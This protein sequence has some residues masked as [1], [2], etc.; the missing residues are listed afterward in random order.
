MLTIIA[1]VIIFGLLLTGAG[2]LFIRAFGATEQNRTEQNRTEQNRTRNPFLYWIIGFVAT[3]IIATAATL[4]APLNGMALIIFTAVGLCG[5][6]LVYRDYRSRLARCDR[7]GK[8][9]FAG[10]AALLVIY[11]ASKSAFYYVYW[12]GYDTALYHAQIVRWY[13]EYGAVCGV[14]NLHSRLAFNSSYL[15][16]AA[17]LDNWIF[18][19]RSAWLMPALIFSG[20][21]LYFLHE[22]FFARKTEIRLY[23]AGVIIYWFYAAMS[24][25]PSLYYDE[26]VHLLNAVVVLEAYYL[27]NRRDR[28]AEK[29]TDMAQLLLLA[30]GAFTIKPIGAVSLIFT[31]GL[32]LFLLLRERANR[33][34]WAI[35]VLPAAVALGIWTARN[36]I[37]SGYPLYPLPILAMPFDWTMTYTEVKGNYD[38][39]VA[40]ARM[41]GAGFL[42]S[43][44][45]GFWFWFA[46]WCARNFSTVKFWILGVLPLLFATLLWVKALRF[47]RGRHSALF[48]LVWGGA[49]ILYWFVSA[50]DMRF[51]GGFFWVNLAAA[52]LFL[53]S[54]ELWR[55]V[56]LRFEKSWLGRRKKWLF[57]GG[58]LLILAVNLVGTA[59]SKR[60]SLIFMGKVTANPVVEH[61]VNSTPPF[62]VWVP[63]TGDQ[64]GDSPLPSSPYP[65]VVDN[66]EMR[67]PGDLGRGFRP[68]S[69]K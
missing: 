13:N 1:S 14:G 35:A 41:P 59:V 47:H 49:N 42:E 32:V 18:D 37:T 3:G 10:V 57:V 52:F 23:A 55:G 51:G 40:W 34:L 44:N 9:I 4:V 12:L 19:A 11:V 7:V 67:V 62:K 64:T 25:G 8:I 65:S 15:S 61:T 31:G 54:T 43:L 30:V 53:N 66:L 56:A 63:V 60:R 24:V 2:A 27:L 20:G 22:W 21:F 38:A 68:V 5:L 33:R 36:L 69:P 48:F 46:P 17:L 26:P 6:P 50:P 28:V 58:L 45:H 29:S 16:F 39:V